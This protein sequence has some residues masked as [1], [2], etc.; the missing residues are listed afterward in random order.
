MNQQMNS[1][2]IQR[3]LDEART[4]AKRWLKEL[5]GPDD[6]AARRVASMLVRLPRFAGKSVEDVLADREHVQ[7]KHTLDAV[8]RKAGFANWADM[9]HE[10]EG[11]VELPP[12]D[13]LRNLDDD[14]IFG[15]G[16]LGGYLH[17]WYRSYEEGKREHERLGGYLLPH[18]SHCFIADEGYIESVGLDPHDP[19]WERIGYDWVRP[20]DDAAFAR[21]D[22]KL[23]TWRYRLQREQKTHR[24]K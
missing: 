24:A 22:R 2:D 1:L 14:K 17:N 8:A 10:W 9:K 21:L 13:Q 15:S 7:L 16:S 12:R 23:D 3:G 20:K 11:D 18:G 19:D 4:R 5:R 6:D